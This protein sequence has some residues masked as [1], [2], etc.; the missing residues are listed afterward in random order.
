MDVEQA[1]S[2]WLDRTSR[3][4]KLFASKKA[5][6]LKLGITIDQWVILAMIGARENITQSE[7]CER[8]F[9]DKASV[10]RISDILEK[11]KLIKRLRNPQNRREYQI[12]CTELG[13]AKIAALLPYVIEARKIGIAGFQEKELQILVSFL[14]RIYENYNNAL[15]ENG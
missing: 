9:K 8:S 6:E 1:F 5:Y 4:M 10:A 11:N 14:K 12:R 7:L 3:M 13:K 2:F 15:H